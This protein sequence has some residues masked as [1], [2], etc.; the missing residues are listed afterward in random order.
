MIKEFNGDRLKEARIYRGVTLVEL[1]EKIGITKQMISKYENDKAIPT[2]EILSKMIMYLNFPKDFF[3]EK[4]NID[5]KVGNIYFR[6]L[7]STSKREQ[8]R[9]QY[10]LKILTAVKAL[11]DNYVDFPKLNIPDFED[12]KENLGYETP[13]EAAE[14]LRIYWDIPKDEPIKNMVHLMEKNGFL[15]SVFDNGSTDIDAFCRKQIL[16]GEES[17]IFSLGGDKHYSARRRFNAAHELGHVVLH[18]SFIDL[19]EI[20]K[21][22][23]KAIEQEAHQ[24]AAAFLLPKEGFSKDIGTH[25]TDIHNYIYYKKKWKVSISAM[26]MRAFNLG[27]INYSQYQTLQRKISYNGWKKTEPL[28]KELIAERPAVIKQAIKLLLDNNILS[29]EGFVNELSL[30]CGLTIYPEELERV[31][32]LERGTLRKSNS[33]SDNEVQLK[34]IK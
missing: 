27:L 17:Y 11:L 28:D 29:G 33:D 18:E 9:Q 1:S 24:F 16:N 5:V 22:Q 31:L 25:P 19:E 3:Y 12:L 23:N 13:E 6:S 34:I 30:R 15:T 8:Q 14:L 26:V 32:G 20:S 10:P 4:D 2:F 7:F 21:D